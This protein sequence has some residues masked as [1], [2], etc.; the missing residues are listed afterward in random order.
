MNQHCVITP[1]IGLGKNDLKT[2]QQSYTLHAALK[3]RW[4][5]TCFG[6]RGLAGVSKLHYPCLPIMG[7]NS[8]LPTTLHSPRPCDH[9]IKTTTCVCVC[10]SVCT[11]VFVYRTKYKRQMRQYF[12]WE[13]TASS[14]EGIRGIPLSEWDEPS[15]VPLRFSGWEQCSV[16]TG[17]WLNVTTVNY[18]NFL[19]G[20]GDTDKSLPLFCPR[21]L[22]T[23]QCG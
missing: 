7:I 2:P 5:W 11:Y 10:A 6:S 4:V 14:N 19:S 18:P 13:D 8:K 16:Q 1:S 17:Y 3:V 23:V 22:V 20:G 15:Y 12:R 9:V 21:L